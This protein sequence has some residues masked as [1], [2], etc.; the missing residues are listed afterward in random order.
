MVERT[1]V[2]IIMPMPRAAA[3]GIQSAMVCRAGAVPVV[4][5]FV[6]V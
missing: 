2:D 4:G 3:D 1:I 5:T 6:R